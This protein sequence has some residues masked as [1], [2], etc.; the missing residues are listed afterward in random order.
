MKIFG[1]AG[2]SE[3]HYPKIVSYIR[4]ARRVKNYGVGRDL[5]VP[6]D[7]AGTNL[8]STGSYVGDEANVILDYLFRGE[9]LKLKGYPPVEFENFIQVFVAYFQ[10]HLDDFD[11]VMLKKIFGENIVDDDDSSPKILIPWEEYNKYK[12]KDF[13]EDEEDKQ[14]K[15]SEEGK[16][17][18]SM[19]N[20]EARIL[21]KKLVETERQ[22]QRM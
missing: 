12:I 18:Q 2:F 15:K 19:Y 20:D 1:N 16:K 8:V 9:I 10:K 4:T 21:N 17:K 6:L 14:E 11:E 5:R 13:M 7:T 3:S 22:L